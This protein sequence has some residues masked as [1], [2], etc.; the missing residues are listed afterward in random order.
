MSSNCKDLYFFG[1]VSSTHQG[2]GGETIKNGIFIGYLKEM[3]F[4]VKV[5]DTVQGKKNKLAFLLSVVWSFL[6]PNKHK[7]VLSAATISAVKYLKLARYLNIHRKEIFYFVIGGTLS[8]RVKSGE[9]S[10]VLLRTATKIFVE[11]NAMVEDLLKEGVMNVTRIPNFKPIPNI[12]RSDSKDG[13]GGLKLVY[14]SRI[15]E[16]KG[17]LVLIEALE[18]LNS[19]HL[20]VSLDFYGPIEQNFE[21]KFF[22]AIEKL[23]NAEYQGILNFADDQTA[24]VKLSTYD[25]K[26]LPTY[27]FG[28]GFPGVFI[29][30]FI[31]G[32]PVLTTDWNYNT[33]VIQNNINGLIISKPTSGLIEKSIMNFS[34]DK[35]LR[36]KLK[37]GAHEASFNYGVNKVLAPVFSGS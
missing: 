2:H 4:S 21:E 1:G 12:F 8:S 10:T 14:V 27:H 15:M 33:E 35:E 22:N 20:N 37:K 11:A 7:I 17:V 6:S 9:L 28:E 19:S 36:E 5:L 16:E 18:K 26:I 29:D 31:A 3:G 30:C 23:D 32:V 24:Y 13:I 25:L 34:F